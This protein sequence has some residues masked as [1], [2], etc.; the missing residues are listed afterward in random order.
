MVIDDSSSCAFNGKEFIC[1]VSVPDLD[2][3]KGFN[4]RVIYR[5]D[6]NNADTEIIPY[7]CCA[8]GLYPVQTSGGVKGGQLPVG[9]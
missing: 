8:G 1:S 3:G 7:G 2:F 6:E 5:S 9:P 4:C